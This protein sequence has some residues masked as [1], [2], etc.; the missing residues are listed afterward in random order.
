MVKGMAA[1]G[2]IVVRPVSNETR[3]S[4]LTIGKEHV[5]PSLG[6]KGLEE[7]GRKAGVT[8]TEMVDRMNR[9]KM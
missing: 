5:S 9:V 7:E 3:V 2:L 6:R 4:C 1:M 8:G